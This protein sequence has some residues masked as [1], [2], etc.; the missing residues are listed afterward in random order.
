MRF[1]NQKTEAYGLDDSFGT[2]DAVLMAQTPGPTI[3]R[4]DF[5]E[6]AD[7]ANNTG[8]AYSVAVGDYFSGRIST[9]G[10]S[11]WLRVT[12]TAG[13]SYVFTAYGTG[14]VSNGLSDT[15]LTLR[16]AQGNIL[17]FNDDAG[18]TNPF[19]AVSITAVTTGT[20]YLDVTGY[21][22]STGNYQVQV[23]T[24]VY[25]P[26]QVA[27]HIAEFNWGFP[28]QFQHDEAV[29]QGSIT[30]NIQGLTAAG[31]QLANWAF[32]VWSATTGLTFQRVTFG[33]EIVL[34]D[35]Q[36]GAFAGPSDINANG[37]FNNATV[38]VE[39]GWLAS[40]GTSIDSYSFFTYLH[41]IGHALGLGHAGEYDGWADYGIDNLYRN[42]SHQMT[43][44]SYFSVSENTFVDGVNG[45]PITPMLADLIAMGW[46][47]GPLVAYAGDTVWGAN[48]T[49][50]GIL[51]Q[52]FAMMAGETAVNPAIFGAGGPVLYTIIDTGGNDLLD[53]SYSDLNARIDLR[54]GQFSDVGGQ[55]NSIAIA[56][57]TVVE[58]LRLGDGNDVVIGND[59]NN[60]ITGNGGN[61]TIDGGLGIDTAI[62]NDTRAAAAVSVIGAAV[63]ISSADGV[64]VF[65]NMDFF[66]FT[67]QT[68]SV[69]EL[70]GLGA[71]LPIEGTAGIDLLMGTAGPDEMNGYGSA[72]RLDG[73]A[74][75][76]LMD[77]G[78]GNDEMLGR[79]GNDTMYGG[80][81]HDNIAASDGDD[82]VYGGE[83]DD[84]LGG[85]NGN[86][87]LYGGA[88]RDV[89][90]SGSNEDMIDAGDGDDTV[91]GGWGRDTVFG[92]NGNDQMAGSYDND[93]VYGGAGNDDMGGGTGTDYMYGGDGND[94]MGAGD[95]DDFMFGGT[96]NDFLGGGSGQ[97]V[98]LG[99]NGNDRLNGGTGNDTLTGGAGADRFIFNTWTRGER[100]TITDFANGEDQFQ[101]HGVA[102]STLEARFAALSITAS[103]AN[104]II[105]YGGHSIVV[106]GATVGQ[107]DLSDFVFI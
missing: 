95:D 31:Q 38:N 97:D 35:N 91:S 83:G 67:D 78:D 59:A 71:P 96:G 24:D 47:Y 84:S 76:D 50:G 40:Y 23:A 11:D 4:A 70:M 102:G 3:R 104:V 13:E 80:N 107:F 26:E 73:G 75:A 21:G 105:S 22:S 72:D 10:E 2:I 51:G 53:V 44:M 33:G 92:G 5:S 45:T 94:L 9:A 100:D 46:A 85:G 79:S 17:A 60:V 15:I 62:I 29:G 63:T 1:A 74:G 39:T 42:D 43:I 7:A 99:E 19:S 14:G 28:G 20:Y 66:T 6:Q 49:L 57:S 101:M 41:E 48:N 58:S 65:T 36:S 56:V 82:L 87:R 90:G 52:V 103:G 30:Y 8:T 68:V 12:L 55:Q 16:D 32:E 93:T 18:G 89:I 77:G 25:T 64:D 34:D 37:I 54:G 69:A 106:E 98:L 61:D 88:G 86:D 27:T 81:G